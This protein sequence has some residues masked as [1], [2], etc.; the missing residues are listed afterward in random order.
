MACGV[1]SSLLFR[2]QLA[3]KQ[4]NPLRIY[5]CRRAA[6]PRKSSPTSYP[7]PDRTTVT[8]S[9]A[10]SSDSKPSTST[11][12]PYPRSAHLHS[13][14]CPLCVLADAPP[15]RT[16]RIRRLVLGQRTQVG[17]RRSG[18]PHRRYRVGQHKP[19]RG[20]CGETHRIVRPY[21]IVT[22]FAFPANLSA[23]L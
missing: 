12:Y 14:R 19:R 17:H 3:P 4:T 7:S 20:E 9:T 8:P 23:R 11:V 16:V 6:S 15:L 1:P 13:D 22:L 10:M 2:A 18:V 21:R 5:T